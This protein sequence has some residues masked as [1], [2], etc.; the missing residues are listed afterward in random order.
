[1]D[2]ISRRA[3]NR[4]TLHRQML[5]ERSTGSVASVIEHLVGMQAQNPHDP[6]FALWARLEGFE[7]ADLSGMIERREAVR[8]QMMRA[9]IHLMTTP[10]FLA[11][12]PQFQSVCARTLGS[13]AFDRDTRDVD[14]ESLLALGRSLLEEK[15][16][17]RAELGPLLEAEWPGIPAGSLAQVVTFLLPV[18]QAPPR[19][20][21]HRSGPAAWTTIESWAG[22]KLAAGAV[23][24]TAVRRY[25]AAFGP[26]SI[27]DM[28]VW[29]GLTGLRE[30][31]GRMRPGFRVFEDESGAELLDLPDAPIMDEDTPAP[32]RFLPEYDNVLLGHSDRSRFFTSDAVP[33]GWAGNLLVD[34]VFSGAWKIG[35][36]K[37]RAQMSV[38]L[39]R[40]LPRRELAGVRQEAD[41]LLA[42]AHPDASD[43]LVAVETTDS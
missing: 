30:V 35:R 20:L 40:K 6:Y 26:A 3:L 27:T 18:I 7:A 12:R 38:R 21:W 9:T 19:G 1:M 23:V 2:R 8:G 31:I 16:R 34:G 13:T 25:L 39:L 4:T 15:P 32:P 11:L 22:T 41:S 5:L 10:D 14:R 36:S 33:Q 43:R 17:T 24:E 42:L 28:R 29:S 37:D